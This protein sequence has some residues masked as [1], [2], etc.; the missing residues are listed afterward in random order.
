[1]A[2]NLPRYLSDGLVGKVKTGKTSNY[3]VRSPLTVGTWAS[4]FSD[5]HV[6][7]GEGTWFCDSLLSTS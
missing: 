1:M 7:V 4:V 5:G 2:V 3:V 6:Y